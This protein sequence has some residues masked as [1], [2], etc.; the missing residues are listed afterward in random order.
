MVILLPV[1]AHIIFTETASCLSVAVAVSKSADLETV[2]CA[3]EQAAAGNK[4]IKNIQTIGKSARLKSRLPI[5]PPCN[6]YVLPGF[7][8]PCLSHQSYQQ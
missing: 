4:L 6:K 7:I 3:G 8:S 5:R 2:V 1:F